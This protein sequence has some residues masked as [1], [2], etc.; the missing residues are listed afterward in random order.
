M[1]AAGSTDGGE[2]QCIY[3]IGVKIRMK[4]TTGKNKTYVGGQYQN[5]S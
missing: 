4:K 3:D 5:G 1:G 2:E